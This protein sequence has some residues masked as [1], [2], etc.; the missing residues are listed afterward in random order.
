MTFGV[1]VVSQALPGT[2]RRAEQARRRAGEDVLVADDAMAFAEAVVR[3]YHDEAL[4]QRLAANGLLNVERHFSLE[5][6][7]DVVRRVLL[8]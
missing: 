7:R 8:A 1:R 5:A 2:E 4:W 6:G 3:A